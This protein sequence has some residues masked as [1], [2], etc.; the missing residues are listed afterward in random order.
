MVV[1]IAGGVFARAGLQHLDEGGSVAAVDR[2]VGIG[3]AQGARRVAAVGRVGAVAVAAGAPQRVNGVGGTGAAGI[4]DR[5]RADVAAQRIGGGG[6]CHGQPRVHRIEEAQVVAV[7]AAIVILGN[8][9]GRPAADHRVAVCPVG[10][11]AVGRAA[12]AGARADAVIGV[13]GGQ[14]D[15]RRTGQVALSGEEI[16]QR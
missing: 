12:D 6:A 7:L 8:G 9:L 13:R 10:G 16:R 5:D 1:E 3:M 14:R 2:F 11:G 15:V 4:L